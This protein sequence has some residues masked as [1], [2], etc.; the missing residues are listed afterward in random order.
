[1]LLMVGK[2]IRGG[3]WHAIYQYANANNKYMK[4]Y[5]KH[6]ESSYLKCWVVNNL[7]GWA[8]PQ[9]LLV[10][11]FLWIED[12]FQLNEDFTKTYIEESDEGHFL[13]NDSQYPEKLYE[14]H[15][16]L[17]FLPETIKIEKV[18]KLVSNLHDKL[19]M[20]FT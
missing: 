1:M 18:K 16:D 11:N 15:N 4:D 5:E 7:Y 6:K 12:T 20:L 17:L 3:I 9:K 8:M 2:S 19:N 14:L 13:K 10:N